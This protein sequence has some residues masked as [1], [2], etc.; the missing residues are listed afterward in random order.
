MTP[1][2]STKKLNNKLL[3]IREKMIKN[4]YNSDT[5]IGF[6]NVLNVIFYFLF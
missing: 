3:K 5:I 4:T 1:T 2:Q 6:I